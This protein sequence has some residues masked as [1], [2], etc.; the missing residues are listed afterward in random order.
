VKKVKSAGHCLTV[1]ATSR[2]KSASGSSKKE[3]FGI[4]MVAKTVYE[5]T[6]LSE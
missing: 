4:K 1:T 6:S 5:H 3:G 2:A